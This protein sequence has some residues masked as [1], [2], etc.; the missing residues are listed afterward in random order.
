MIVHKA[1]TKRRRDWLLYINISVYFVMLFHFI[2]FFFFQTWENLMLLNERSASLLSSSNDSRP[3]AVLYR[4]CTAVRNP[5]VRLYT[6]HTALQV[7]HNNCLTHRFLAPSHR[8]KGGLAC[9]TPLPLAPRW[10]R[11]SRSI[12]WRVTTA[13][14]SPTSRVCIAGQ[15]KDRAPLVFFYCTTKKRTYLVMDSTLNWIS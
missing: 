1:Q 14:V 10:Q 7:A 5:R 15:M 2:I 12:S 9:C 6:T 4:L 3:P 8:P 13:T 11:Q